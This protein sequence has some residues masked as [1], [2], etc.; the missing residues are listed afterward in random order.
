MIAAGM[1][2][3]T[4]FTLFVTPAIYTLL[5]KDHSRDRERLS[6]GAATEDEPAHKAEAAE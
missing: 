1:A 6:H 2:I 4:L 5:A 3:G